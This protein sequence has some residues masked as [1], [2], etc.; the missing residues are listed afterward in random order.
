M[1]EFQNLEID[2]KQ[3]FCFGFCPLKPVGGNGGDMG[4]V[5]I[6]NSSTTKGWKN[7][8]ARRLASDMAT[9][10]DASYG[11]MCQTV[12]NDL[13]SG[14]KYKMAFD[15]QLCLWRLGIVDSPLA[16]ILPEQA[17]GFF[18]NE[19]AKKFANR[20]GDYIDRAVRVYRNV[21]EPHL[22]SGELTAV[23]EAKLKRLLDLAESDHVM[24]DNLR[25]MKYRL[26]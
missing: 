14:M 10:V 20:C 16:D 6:A 12:M 22:V 13:D 24:V 4:W 5:T 17:S 1:A 19:Y 25:G 3:T 2:P 18:G 21:V 23:S 11:Y 9:N 8:D 15:N 26:N 7:V